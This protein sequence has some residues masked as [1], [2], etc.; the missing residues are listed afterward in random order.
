MAGGLVCEWVSKR[1]RIHRHP[2]HRLREALLPF[3]APPSDEFWAVRRVAFT[4][5]SGQALAAIGA[6]G[7][8][9]STLLRLLAG[10]LRP[11]E[12]RIERVGQVAALLDASVGFHAELSG[13]ENVFLRAQL[14][15]LPTAEVRRRF[16][17]IVAF[18][19]LERFID[20]PIR[21]W[22]TGMAIR[23][24]FAIVS[25]LE[26]DV[27]V[28]DEVLAAGDLS[29]QRQALA[30]VRELKARG[31]AVVVATHSI[32]DIGALCERMVWLDQGSVAAQ[33]TPDEVVRAYVERVE[34]DGSRIGEGLAVAPV[35]PVQPTG[36]VRIASV[37][38]N[39]A[40]DPEGVDLACGQPLEI[41]LDLVAERPVSNPLV[42]VQFHR[43]DGLMVHGS[44]TYR[45]GLDLGA[46]EGAFRVTLTYDRFELLEGEYWIGLGIWP[47]EYRSLATGTPY[48]IHQGRLLLRVTQSRQDGAGVAG[49]R[50]RWTVG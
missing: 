31:C 37:T 11:T 27:L 41:V 17:P 47:D 49:F 33:G 7:S 2:H 21:T 3:A 6:N 26:F 46:V 40:R 44:N 24:G 12:G 16:D 5:A 15:G 18:S 20:R 42:R 10:T 34:R 28:I 29:F 25:H 1:F 50:A 22:S 8:G 23:L 35:A 48:D 9:K 14:Q 19:G 45:H 13:R 38:L 43:N 39:G 36:E 30:K 32:R 4:V